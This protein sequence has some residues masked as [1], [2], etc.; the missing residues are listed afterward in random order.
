MS[1]EIKLEFHSGVVRFDAMGNLFVHLTHGADDPHQV[2]IDGG[3]PLAAP[4]KDRR[5][6]IHG[7]ASGTV[8]GTWPGVTDLPRGLVIEVKG[9]SSVVL[10]DDGAMDVVLDD[11][12]NVPDW[13]QA[14]A[15]HLFARPN[16]LLRMWTKSS[17][18]EGATLDED[19]TPKRP[20]KSSTVSA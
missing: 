11:V 3:E 15:H 8:Q 20:K 17:V 16:E 13:M 2:V 7:S 5:A 10:R 14:G 19:A 6:R 1:T 9:Y 12:A 4:G 18:P